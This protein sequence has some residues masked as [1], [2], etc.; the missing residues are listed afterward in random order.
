[1]ADLRMPAINHTV[2]SGHL[3]RECN[4]HE[5]GVAHNGLCH[6]RR[7]KGEDHATWWNLVAFGTTAEIL[8]EQPKGAP[9]VVEGRLEIRD[10]QDKEG[11]PREEV[12]I[13]CQYIHPLAWRDDAAEPTPEPA[14]IPEDDIPF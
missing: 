10:T 12:Q 11:K 1:M 13:V 4:V 7:I 8:A 3:G 2:L 6:S 5:S 9:V 14:P